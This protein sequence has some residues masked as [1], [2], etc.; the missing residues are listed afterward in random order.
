MNYSCRRQAIQKKY[1]S[2]AENE[3]LEPSVWCFLKA[4]YGLKEAPRLWFKDID[5][6]FQSIDL[7]HSSAYPNLF[8]HTTM[9]VILLLCV[10]DILIVGRGIRDS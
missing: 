6:H 9:Q 1:S 7:R 3:A 5:A 8:A 10:G 4:L 2:S